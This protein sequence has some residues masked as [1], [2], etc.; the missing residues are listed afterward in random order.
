VL[1]S[2]IYLLDLSWLNVIPLLLHG[3]KG[4]NDIRMEEIREGKINALEDN[5][6]NN[7]KIQWAYL[8]NEW[9]ENCKGLHHKIKENAQEEDQEMKIETT[10]LERYQAEQ[11][12]GRKRRRVSLRKTESG[13]GDDDDDDD[14]EYCKVKVKL[15]L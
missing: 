9:R 8:K 6:V 1:K 10:G 7:N 5:L 2:V 13:G 14:D 15:F 12:E 4:I 11:A 3:L